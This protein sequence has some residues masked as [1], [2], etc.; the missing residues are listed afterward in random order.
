MLTR[1]AGIVGGATGLT[2]L[3]GPLAGAAYTA[4]SAGGTAPV[5][6]ALGAAAIGGPGALLIGI[7]GGV[8]AAKLAPFVAK[9]ALSTGSKAMRFLWDTA[10]GTAQGVWEG[11]TGQSPQQAPSAPMRGMARN[12]L[13]SP[14]SPQPNLSQRVSQPQQPQ[15]GKAD[16][17]QQQIMA[18]LQ[19]LL[20]DP[21]EM[22]KF[23]M[24]MKAVQRVVAA[25]PGQVQKQSQPTQQPQPQM[26]MQAKQ[27]VTQPVKV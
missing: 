23:Q 25:N 3:T 12:A 16:P 5:A 26:P 2:T 9:A 27:S 10:K 21:M 11:A 1:G 8:V 4:L 14:P 17:R 19:K 22:Q 18:T 7:A 15:Q 20:Q 24:A 13:V 6:A